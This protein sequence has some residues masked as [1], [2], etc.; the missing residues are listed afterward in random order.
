M[1]LDKYDLKVSQNF[2][3]FQFVSEGK[4]GKI[5]KGI[6]FTLIEA[7]NI[8][9]LGFGDIDAISGEISDLVVSDNGDSEK[10]LATVAQSALVFSEKYPDALIYAEGS[11]PSR[12]RLY[13]IGLSRNFEKITETFM[14][15]GLLDDEWYPFQKNTDYQA[16]V[17]KRKV[18]KFG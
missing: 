8:W 18:D 17:V 2:I 13:R 3:S 1:N 9:N 15:W 11:T 10:I 12:T 16:F 5:L 14:I 7:P 4:N 6:I